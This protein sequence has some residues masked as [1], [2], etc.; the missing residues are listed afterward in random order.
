MNS[1][2]CDRKHQV[3][4]L[5]HILRISSLTRYII[6]AS[7]ALGIQRGFHQ[8]RTTQQMKEHRQHTEL[9]YLFTIY[10]PPPFTLNLL[11]P[12]YQPP[13]AIISAN[14]KYT[15]EHVSAC[16]DGTI[17]LPATINCVW[18]GCPMA[19]AGRRAI[20]Q[21]AMP[22]LTDVR[23]KSRSGTIQI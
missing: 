3:R 18:C 6:I 19:E 13:S 9:D 1:W 23:K 17:Y 21:N 16:G 10:S 8:C 7:S 4:D 5:K 2:W 14:L 11:F 12:H 22:L 15:W 20:I